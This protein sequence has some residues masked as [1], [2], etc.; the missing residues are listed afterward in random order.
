MRKKNHTH[1]TASSA[2]AQNAQIARHRAN[3]QTVHRLLCRA[4]EKHIVLLEMGYINTAMYFHRTSLRP[5]RG[6]LSAASRHYTAV[7]L[8]KD[9]I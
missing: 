7:A 2:R 8:H 6:I 1:P 5:L 3:C 9:V 4:E